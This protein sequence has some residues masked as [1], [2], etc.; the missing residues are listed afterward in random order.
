MLSV[1]SLS[2]SQLIRLIQAVLRQVVVVEQIARLLLPRDERLIHLGA[3][4]HTLRLHLGRV[5]GLC[6]RSGFLI[7]GELAEVVADV[8]RHG[9]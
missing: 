4:L 9:R 6:G 5:T 8:A 1:D 7:D 2:R 3:L